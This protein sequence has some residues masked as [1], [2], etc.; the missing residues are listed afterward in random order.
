MAFVTMSC[1][2]LLT[3]EQAEE[4]AIDSV[5]NISEGNVEQLSAES[6]RPFLFE[7]EILISE[8]LVNDLWNALAKSGYLLTNPEVVDAITIDSTT[9]VRFYNE[10]W[11]VE[12]W[13]N[14]YA[15]ENCIMVE[16]AGDEGALY[17][18][19]NLDKKSN[20]L[21]GLAEVQDE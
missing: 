1:S 15:S 12:Q 17:L 18:I 6:G 4:L 16:V 11:E 21:I 2:T 14:N 10:S 20:P 7:G 13:F 5:T 8:S 19:I 3:V 9:P